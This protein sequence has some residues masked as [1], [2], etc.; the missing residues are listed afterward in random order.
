MS[1][2]NLGDLKILQDA[3]ARIKRVIENDDGENPK[4]SQTMAIYEK[5]WQDEFYTEACEILMPNKKAIAKP[6]LPEKKD[7]SVRQN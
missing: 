7:L 3:V 2:K 4:F 1:R 5:K 6:G